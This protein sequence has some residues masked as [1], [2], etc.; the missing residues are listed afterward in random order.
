[1]VKAITLIIV[2]IVSGGLDR[3]PNSFSMKRGLAT[4]HMC[5]KRSNSQI[6][7]LAFPEIVLRDVCGSPCEVLSQLGMHHHSHDGMFRLRGPE[8]SASDFP[9]AILAKGSLPFSHA[10]PW[11]QLLFSPSFIAPV[12][13]PSVCITH[14]TVARTLPLRRSNEQLPGANIEPNNFRNHWGSMRLS[15]GKGLGCP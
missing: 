12:P 7:K 9:A 14:A 2:V 4:I 15:G 11:A 1:M 3:A 8:R 5:V 6:V 10:H 13:W